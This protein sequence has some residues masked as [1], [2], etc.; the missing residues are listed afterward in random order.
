MVSDTLAGYLR[1][2]SIS[3][4][5]MAF[6]TEDDL[7]SVPAEGGQA[8]RL[9]ADLLGIGHP[10]VSPDGKLVAFTSELQGQP[11]VYLVLTAGGVARRLTWLGAP[12]AR[13]TRLD[14]PTKVLTWA[15][16]GRVVYATDAGQPFSALSMAYAISTEGPDPAEPLPYGP[17]RDASYGPSGGVV[18]GRNTADPALWKRY[19]GGR[20]GA[21][22]IDRAGSGAFAP[23]LLPEQV[24]GNL[25][26]PMW[27]GD[28]VFFL[29][30][31]EGI[32]NLYSCSLVGSGI[33]RHTDHTE[34]YARLA[35]SD[36]RRIVYQVAGRLW[37]YDPAA[38]RANEVPVEVGSPRGQR[39]PRFVPADEYLGD[40]QLDN[41]GKRLVL[42]TRGK[43][44]SFAPFDGPV[45]QHGRSQGTR[46]RL[47]SFLGEGTDVVT[48][49]DAS[50]K[51][52]IEIHRAPGPTEISTDGRGSAPS[53]V[54]DIPGL[55][56]V[57][58]LVPSPDGG[59]LAV[60][61]HQHQLILVSVES[62]QW[63]VLDES[64]FGEPA[65][66]TWS[67]DGKW[68]AYSFPARGKTS[69]VKLADIDGGATIAVTDAQFRDICPSFDP[70]GKYLYFLSWRTFD[71]VY[72]SLFFDLGFPR[73]ARPYLVTLQADLPSPFL[74][75]PEPPAEHHEEA[76]PA[77]A[78]S[79]SDGDAETSTGGPTE[80]PFRV[81][82]EGI[83]GRVLEVPVPEARYEMLIALKDK[84]LLLSR[85]IEGALGHSWAAAGPPAN[86]VLEWYDLVEDRRETLATEVAE[87]ASSG[88]RERLAY[89]TAGGNDHRLRVVASSVKPDKEHENDPP[90][91][92]SGF[93]D[94]GRVRVLVDPG[95]EW[96]QM[97]REAWR[98]Q[99]EQFWTADLSGVDW[100]Q[101]LDRYL[102]LVER[103]ATRTELSDLIWELQGELGTSHAYEFGGEYRDPPDW[104][105]AHLGADFQRDSSGRWAV[106]RI[107]PGS[108]WQPEEASPLLT[109]GADVRV[110]TVVL[111]LNGQPLD[112]AAGLGPLL[113][114]QAGQPVQLTVVSPAQ[115]GSE[116]PEPR[117]RTIVVPT[118][119]DD[120]P[121]RYRE[122]V[123]SNRAR[124]REATGGRAGYL[125]VPDM[126]P[127]GW[128]EFHRSYQVEVE[129]D[130]LVVDARFNG[131]GH[132]S[133]LVLEKLARR[134]IGWEMPR[135]G[136]PITY[137]D[138]AP[139]GPLVLLTNE[140]AGS[141]G[142]IFTHGF[143][144]LGLG[145]VVG[146]RT[147]GGVIGID[148]TMTLVDGTVT[149]QPEYA[150]WFED[151]GWGIENHGADPD[152]EVVITPQDYAAGRDPQLERAIQLVLDAL[153]KQTPAHAEF[154]RRP[155]K[156]LPTLPARNAPGR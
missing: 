78:A 33:T 156:Q 56:R 66:L 7:W 108:S 10:V 6:V 112:P 64:A 8:R 60:T 153:A 114:N 143:K 117:L 52:N 113:A 102:P 104:G 50:G 39:Q 31:H 4:D 123:A 15:P 27:V 11:D 67:P 101:V 22:W 133:G 137:P 62:G 106:S 63:R 82:V 141:D 132:T 115:P 5:T 109:P 1:L 118:L 46:Y 58:E 119:A 155:V 81:D 129:R 80:V 142:D 103:V 107:V 145:P 111:A 9:T 140:V 126:M 124:V 93:V 99:P 130:A 149:T 28:R 89:T 94:L 122:W 57:I 134:R 2:A 47:A 14:S 3:G 21:I 38:D 34:H 49:S 19:R 59:H 138:E 48:V 146:A 41:T 83:E 91:R 54:L 68:V 152:E 148:L 110:G 79:R 65:G 16:D 17:V 92:S 100:Q 71:P 32:G 116:E 53:Q 24:G 35:G 26:S 98:L 37:L 61:N 55:G 72:D 70:T 95:P 76:E 90:G 120:R 84:V 75:R 69:Q 87:L 23:L 127:L 77:D 42:D 30:D 25:A 144:L 45:L 105:Q 151:V 13:L 139:R 121:L 97:L 73:G 150:F 29:S 136:A 44:F 18:I 51:E 36:G 20:A 85:P 128:S 96:A 86:G 135:R 125:H 131:G 74:V 147:W 12:G 154:D 40:Y 43:L 88:D